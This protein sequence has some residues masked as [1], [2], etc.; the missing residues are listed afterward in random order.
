[1]PDNPDPRLQSQHSVITGILGGIVDCIEE[2]CRPSKDQS[3]EWH[4]H[5]Q[6]LT[7]TLVDSLHV[8]L[9]QLTDKASTTDLDR[10]SV[11]VNPT[12]EQEV[13]LQELKDHLLKRVKREFQLIQGGKEPDGQPN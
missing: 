13:E 10:L 1:M 4:F 11:L 7:Q 9:V 2:I 6:A 8:I 5:I 12:P 3:D